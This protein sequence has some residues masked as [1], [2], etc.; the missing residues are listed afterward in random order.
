MK[1]KDKN[2]N[3]I[4]NR[5][6]TAIYAT[7]VLELKNG[8]EVFI[9]EENLNITSA[10]LDVK[11][12]KSCGVLKNG[13]EYYFALQEREGK[14]Y[15]IDFIDTENE[16][17]E[18]KISDRNFRR[19]FPEY[20]CADKIEDGYKVK[21]SFEAKVKEIR[22]ENKYPELIIYN[23]E[24]EYKNCFYMSE[25]ELPQIEHEYILNCLL[26]EAGI[27]VYSI[28]DI[29]KTAV[30]MSESEFTE[31]EGTVK[32]IKLPE[33]NENIF[34]FNIIT[35]DGGKITAR[36]DRNNMK[37][38]TVLTDEKK[39]N[40]FCYDNDECI[41]HH[42]EMIFENEKDIDTN[43]TVIRAN[44]RIF[45]LQC[46]ER[47]K[48]AGTLIEINVVTDPKYIF[49][50][51]GLLIL[52]TTTIPKYTCLLDTT[53]NYTTLCEIEEENTYSFCGVLAGDMVYLK[54]VKKL[55]K[56][57]VG[58][59]ENITDEKIKKDAA[60]LSEEK[61]REIFRIASS[62]EKV[63]AADDTEVSSFVSY[64]EIKRKYEIL[65]EYYPKSVQNIIDNTLRTSTVRG[66]QKDKILEC[67]INTEWGKQIKLNVDYDY[68]KQK[69]D[70]KFYGQD[71]LKEHII[72]TLAS[73]NTKKE[74]KGTNILLVG[75]PG[76][77]KTAIWKYACE[78][79]GM[80]FEKISLNGIETPC[81]LK[82]TPRLYENSTYGQI[83][84]AIHDK[85]DHC[86]IM[87]DEVDKMS[88]TGQ[89]GN[90][91]NS[92]YDVLDREELFIDNMIE[93]GIDL[94]NIIFVLTANDIS[95]LTPAILDRV[96]IRYVPGYTNEEKIYLTKEYIIE[97][98]LSDYETEKMEIVWEEGAVESV[99]TKYAL[100]NVRDIKNNVETVIKSA[101]NYMYKNRLDKFVIND[102]NIGDMLGIV[103][104][105][106]DVI[107]YD[108]AGLKNK[109][110]YFRD[111]YSDS[112]K[113]EI[114]KLFIKYDSAM[115][116]DEKELIRKKLSYIVNIVP[117]NTCRINDLKSIKEKLDS[118]HYGMDEAKNA[119]I[120]YVAVHN[121]NPNAS[122]NCL[123]LNGPYGVGKTSLAETIAESMDRSFI[124]ISLNGIA[125]AT[126]LKGFETT[127]KDSAAGKIIEEL[128]KAGTDNVVILLD[129]V[130]K[131]KSETSDPYSS[132]LDLLD[133]SAMFTDIFLGF[134]VD[135][136]NIFFIA[137]SND[138]F[139]IPESIK[140]R[141]EI[142][143]LAGY[144]ENEK[145]YIA[146]EYVL[147]KKIKEF[148]IDDAG[149][150]DVSIMDI[151][152]DYCSSYG[153][154]DVSQ[155]FDKILREYVKEKQLGNEIKNINSEFVKSVLGAKP[156]KRG[157]VREELTVSGIT[158]ALAVC[159]NVGTTFAVQATENTYGTDDEI[160]GL[161]K[162][163]VVDSI[164]IS[165]LLVSKMLK[166]KLPAM[167][168]HFAEGGIEKD[169]PSAGITIFS[170]LY[171]CMINQPINSK[172]AM[173]GEIDVFGDV[174]PIGGVEQKIIAAQQAGCEITII[175]E[176]NYHQLE[177]DE[178][179]HKYHIK[180]VPVKNI[181]E[182]CDK[183]FEKDIV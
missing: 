178:K 111:S 16:F 11:I 62:C 24:F 67:M 164:K 80:P 9:K 166:K 97:R 82:G 71:S 152:K 137:T 74:K 132:L 174:W 64:P 38:E 65:K 139:K 7:D 75:P 76:V 40:F 35:D 149:I 39:Y 13:G 127:I 145:T 59:K 120:S 96:N 2:S 29:E 157:N 135:V 131:M 121:I 49:Q 129:E 116:K 69:L 23:E 33:P 107:V 128:A 85:S 88:K 150:L 27:Y 54:S 31:V 156:L 101:L 4:Y 45:A 176:G 89:D 47:E 103:P 169:G 151:V 22:H 18:R 158:R 83:I 32:F 167:H 115:E 12:C 144:T 105:V 173:T 163:S 141:M 148:G 119:I 51:N 52:E 86:C 159:G 183:L 98:E 138:V 180:I 15:I 34:E 109:F 114:Q 154:R 95:E 46:F 161:P 84:K 117:F 44:D 179:L 181:Q 3:E 182:L 26:N 134:P 124:K 106:R 142:V 72:Q 140:D 66:K 78:I 155:A 126:Y 99:A 10:I 77:G 25:Q 168:F 42:F 91:M 28:C 79:S 37:S 6:A 147:A 61:Q 170:A 123:L 21:V 60:C 153:I 30:R 110:M 43:T 133:D 122:A 20:S 172:I 70:K 68:L 56:N 136:S 118:S 160:T 177:E 41:V 50:D 19:L 112:A 57:Y 113:K 87:L 58:L 17:I 102:K 90:P 63:G 162:Q 53:M 92:L 48:E 81:F 175:P 100:S 125:T 93:S 165:K 36:I 73:Y 5:K 108:I 130:D 171:S 14:T 104:C 94:S 8:L 143:E 146:E 55:D 1:S